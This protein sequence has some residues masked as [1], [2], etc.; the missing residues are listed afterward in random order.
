MKKRPP[1][2]KY[3][4]NIAKEIAQRSTCFRMKFGAI[5]VKDDAIVAT[6][7]NGAPRKTRDCFERGECLRD[8][9]KI[10][11]GQRYEL[12]RSV[13]SEQNCLINAAR[14]GASVLGG[15]IFIYAET[16][17]G[18]TVNALPC[19]I[20]KK[21]LI[22]AGLNRVVCSTNDGEYRIFNV[23]DWVKDWQEGDVLDDKQQYGQDQNKKLKEV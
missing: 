3:Y 6:G 5:I 7:Y 17:Q 22:N 11:H 15:D 16:V 4:L 1:K 23:Q 12:C 13:H 9:M 8:E 21:M 14:S 10:P 2:D 20:C 18:K 19:F